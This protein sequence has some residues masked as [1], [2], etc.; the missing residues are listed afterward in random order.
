MEDNNWR[1]ELVENYEGRKGVEM[2]SHSGSNRLKSCDAIS[3][4]VYDVE[5][6]TFSAQNGGILIYS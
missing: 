4:D 2:S 5:F 3:L 1:S 6:E